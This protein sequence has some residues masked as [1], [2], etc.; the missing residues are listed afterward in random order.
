M[1]FCQ[2]PHWRQDLRVVVEFYRCYR[3]RQGGSTKQFLGT[4]FY[5]TFCISTFPSVCQSSL[6]THIIKKDATEYIAL[7]NQDLAKK[8]ILCENCGDKF[9]W[10]ALLGLFYLDYTTW[11]ALVDA[12]LNPA[13]KLSTHTAPTGSIAKISFCHATRSKAPLIIEISPAALEIPWL[14]SQCMLDCKVQD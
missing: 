6:C 7:P 10:I 1:T 13:I 9:V 5:D 12:R 14:Y 11:T 3:W 4:K 2:N 8:V